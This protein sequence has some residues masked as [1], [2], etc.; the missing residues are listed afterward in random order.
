MSNY[1]KGSMG[2][3]DEKNL[4]LAL[5]VFSAIFGVVY[6]LFLFDF[7]T[8]FHHYFKEANLFWN[9]VAPLSAAGHYLFLWTKFK[10]VDN[11]IGAAVAPQQ[12]AMWGW[13]LLNIFLF[14]GWKFPLPQ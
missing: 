11:P 6:L 12:I 14:A 10:N 13:F 4:K 1:R 3:A 7:G 2:A 9:I 8:F 5:K